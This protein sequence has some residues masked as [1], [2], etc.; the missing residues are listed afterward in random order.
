[1]DDECQTIYSIDLPF[2][3]LLFTMNN[4]FN[5]FNFCHYS[6]KLETYVVL[7]ENPTI[8]SPFVGLVF[9]HTALY[10]LRIVSDGFTPSALKMYHHSQFS[11]V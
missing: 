6:L 4:F 8:L 5:H 1:M 2:P 10:I 7:K 9:S 3:N 11:V